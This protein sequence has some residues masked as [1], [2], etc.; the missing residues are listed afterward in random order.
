MGFL[1]ESTYKVDE[2]GRVPIPPKFR[3]ELQKGMVLSRGIEK[4][5]RIFP[6]TEWEKEKAKVSVLPNNDKGRAFKRFFFGGAYEEKM[7]RL[8]RI[9]LPPVLRQYAQIGDTVVISGTDSFLE[10]WNAEKWQAENVRNEEDI[11][12][13]AEILASQQHPL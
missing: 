3:G 13:T 10:L 4:C 9:P 6:L 8:G 12:Q 1:G 5:I 11:W 2:K 7:D